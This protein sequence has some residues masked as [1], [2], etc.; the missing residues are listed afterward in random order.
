MCS[1]GCAVIEEIKKQDLI[2]RSA[3]LGQL[4]HDDLSSL[5]VKVHGKG[6]M[7]GLVLDYP[8]EAKRVYELCLERGVQ[9]VDTGRRWI[10]IGPQLNIEEEVLFEGIKIVKEVIEQVVSERPPET[11][12]DPCEEFEGS[13]SVL[14]VLPI[15]SDLSLKG[16]MALQ[17]PEDRED[18]GSQG[19]PN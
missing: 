17:A 10:K 9:V 4:M 15:S 7:A 1:V 3:W 13:D 12:G 11:C 16:N 19:Q 6:L 14:P 8:F 2:D 5:P 18:G